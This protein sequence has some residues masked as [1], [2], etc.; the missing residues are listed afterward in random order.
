MLILKSHMKTLTIET[1]KL[2]IIQK[3][4]IFFEIL[5]VQYLLQTFMMIMSKYDIEDD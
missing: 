5:P 4:Y 1:K 3:I 2:R